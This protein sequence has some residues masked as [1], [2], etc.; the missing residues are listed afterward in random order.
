MW[1]AMVDALTI[2]EH[3]TSMPG[4]SSCTAD[5]DLAWQVARLEALC[6]QGRSDLN[7]AR[8]ASSMHQQT[9]SLEAASRLDAEGQISSLRFGRTASSDDVYCHAAHNAAWTV[10]WVRI[11]SP[12]LDS[13]G[14]E[15][16]S[17]TMP[18]CNVTGISVSLHNSCMAKTP[19]TTSAGMHSPH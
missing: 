13:D 17:T 6:A 1:T 11:N 16:V 9:C 7:A 8:A 3:P 2:C 18:K 14:Q 10:A 4:A 19:I 12:K 15:R 5:I